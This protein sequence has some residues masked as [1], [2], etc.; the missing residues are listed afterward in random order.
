MTL[1]ICSGNTC[2]SFMAEQ[3]HTYHYGT[4]TA[5]S[6]GL[7]A[8]PGSPANPK[9]VW[10]LGELF[11]EPGPH[12]AK[13]VTAQ[14]LEAA[15]LVLTMERA[16]AALLSSIAPEYAGKIHALLPYALDEQDDVADPYGGDYD[17]YYA[18]AAKLDEAVR[19]LKGRL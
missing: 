17:T 15:D 11:V 1:Y 3:L 10:A 18:C 7:A 12:R 6:A 9:A 5:D 19:A 8:Y 2:R 16:Q 13:P 4:G 14:L